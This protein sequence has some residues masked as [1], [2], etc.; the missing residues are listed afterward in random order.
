MSQIVV[1]WIV[2]AYT[3]SGIVLALF[4]TQDVFQ[5]RYRSAFIWLALQ[6]IVDATDGVLARWAR[7]SDV[8]PWFSGRHLD[9]IVDYVAY[10]F[11][12]A[13]FVWRSL[14]VPSGWTA[15]VC[16]A[17]LLSSAYG[18]SRSDAKT[19]DH[20]FAGFPSYWNIV[21]FY[22]LLGGW[23]QEV[24]G[25]VLIALALLVFAP[26]YCV[27]PS[28]TPVLRSTT[29]AL[30]SAWG[31]VVLWMLWR[32]PAV[33]RAIFWLSMAF[34]AYYTALSFV[35]SARRTAAVGRGI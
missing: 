33:P 30:G 9:D 3:A 25:A 4:A 23:S 17:M 13:L 11:V 2:H 7:V 34:P 14:L 18:F 24:N 10:V 6:V 5:Y 32:M 1:A 31:A 12:P 20:L 35:L 28:R 16:S 21:V 22:L 26:I 15:V 29:L 19:T 27:Y 8:I